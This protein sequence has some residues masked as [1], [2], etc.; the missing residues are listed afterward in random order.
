M[1]TSL[2]KI[3]AAIVGVM[4][5]FIIPVYIAFEKVDDVSYSLALKL[6]QNFVDNVRDKG[7]ISPEMYSDFV[8]GLYATNNTYDVN[9]EHVKKRYDPA[10]YIYEK[11]VDNT[12]GR[13]LRV[14]DYDK[15]LTAEGELPTTIT[16]NEGIYNKT[17]SNIIVEKASMTMA[18]GSQIDFENGGDSILTPEELYKLKIDEF[19]SQNRIILD[20]GE[21]YADIRRITGKSFDKEIYNPAYITLNSGVVTV[22]NKQGNEPDTLNYNEYISNYDIAIKN[23]SPK[24]NG[25]V[26]T[27]SNSKIVYTPATMYIDGM[28][29]TPEQAKDFYY[30]WRTL[31]KEALASGDGR[32]VYD[33]GEVYADRDKVKT[34]G[35]SID[36]KID[37][38]ADI[39]LTKGSIKINE[40]KQQPGYETELDYDTYIERYDS[41]MDMVAYAGEIYDNQN[42]NIISTRAAMWVGDKSYN[43]L[44]E[45]EKDEAESLYN[46]KINT[47]LY[48]DN[49]TIVLN[50]GRIFAESEDAIGYN[51][52]TDEIRSIKITGQM[53]N[54][55]N[56]NALYIDS[57]PFDKYIEEYRKNGN[58]I[59]DEGGT[60][61]DGEEGISIIHI[62]GRISNLDGEEFDYNSYID[63]LLNGNSPTISVSVGADFNSN[64]IYIEN[65]KVLVNGNIEKAIS[66]VSELKNVKETGKVTIDGVEYDSN[67]TENPDDIQIVYPTFL[68]LQ[69][70]L[71]SDI[72]ISDS[73]E[74]Q[75]YVD[76]YILNGKISYSYSKTYSKAELKIDYESVYINDVTGNK[77]MFFEHLNKTA[78]KTIFTD[79]ILRN[80]D[81]RNATVNIPKTVFRSE[82]FD[83][84][85]NQIQIAG[86][87]PIDITNETMVYVDQYYSNRRIVLEESNV[88]SGEE[89]KVI[90]P[91]LEIFEK[92]DTNLR[93]SIYSFQKNVES[94]SSDYIKYLN[95]FNANG[96]ITIKPSRIYGHDDVTVVRS[97]ITISPEESG[98]LAS[99]EF[100]DNQDVYQKYLT[101][102]ERTGKI[103]I[104][105]AITY[106]TDSEITVQDAHI[107]ITPTGY[108]S[109]MIDIY[110]EDN[111]ELYDMYVAE[112][113]QNNR[114]TLKYNIGDVNVYRANITIDKLEGSGGTYNVANT[115]IVYD[116]TDLNGDGTFEYN[117]FKTEYE[118]KGLITFAGARQILASDLKVTDPSIT[119]IDPDTGE[120]ILKYEADYSQ[121]TDEQRYQIY[122]MRVD[123]WEDYSQ[124]VNRKVTYVSGENCIIEKA[125]V[126]N[127]EII[128]DKQIVSKI[129]KDTGVSKIEFLR[130]C[131]LGNGDMYKSLSYLNENSYTM[132]EGDQINVIVKNRN[133]T[134]ASVFYSMFTANVGNEDIPKVYVNYGGTIKNSGDT[135][136]SNE[137][138]LVNSELGRLFKYKGQAESVT[139][140]PG[141]YQIEAWG[142]SGG[143]N[144][145]TTSSTTGGKGAYAKAVFN[146]TEETT[147]YVYVGG[148]G[149]AYSESN[150]YNGGFNGGGNSYNGFGGGGASDVRLLRG[151]ADDTASLLSRIIVAG[152]GGGSSKA[153]GTSYGNGGAAGNLSSA[154]N[155]TSVGVNQLFVGKGAIS[156][157]IAVGYNTYTKE[158]GTIQ[159]IPQTEKGGLGT[160]GSV[161]FDGAGAG[162]GGYFGGSAAHDE[163]AGGGGG[164]SFVYQNETNLMNGDRLPLKMIFQGKYEQKVIDYLKTMVD[165][166]GRWKGISYESSEIKNGTTD[167][168]NPFSY[169]GTSNMNGN[170]GNG[171]VIIKK[172]D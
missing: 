11:K 12:K 100:S 132:N 172:I 25:P 169:S 166:N 60:F 57:L 16:L 102:F 75:K 138:G 167:M 127:E 168:K 26:Y 54:K 98:K 135:I 128:T 35:G 53:T 77:Y 171:A 160:G 104:R 58:F 52:L 41:G 47:N 9:I 95:E 45:A 27:S 124:I 109:P 162:G 28:N 44:S 13:L 14:L 73:A 89:I 97:K 111:K 134:V 123:E 30:T 3:I 40:D 68:V 93:Y 153:R 4:I 90:H 146:V 61:S 96:K 82:D 119:I 38:I 69:N 113:S 42:S 1:E 126:I 154:S 7:Y 141:K 70:Q 118:A 164:L 48:K 133:Q 170:K 21:I 65:A 87:T 130:N 10:I 86:E 142:A 137:T 129:F 114:I 46:E 31:Y 139:L 122:N 81:N 143:G 163:Y 110:E 125:H 51:S 120:V 15:Y 34:T 148:Q 67:K 56:P 32:L 72:Q 85:Y 151:D 8:S 18:D 23:N 29:L 22:L 79:E 115:Q 136:I 159:N 103:T 64:D 165:S 147:L 5:L 99:K 50:K 33:E 155:G 92:N 39:S 94:E 19:K 63:E 76:E 158:D 59:Y 116:N 80:I 91:K 101:E 78:Y 62:K 71:K 108:T 105:P 121:L 17:N 6:T 150:E 43:E 112:Y 84:S 107:S 24:F 88:A 140:N 83:L 49:N 37:K 117:S 145:P 20:K 152:G 74:I 106:S 131:M 2:Q 66:D 144:E 161:D 149:S 156:T 157:A 55:K 36:T